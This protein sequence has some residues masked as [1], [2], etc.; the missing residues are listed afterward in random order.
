MTRSVYSCSERPGPDLFVHFVGEEVDQHVLRDI[1]DSPRS[2]K[3]DIYVNLVLSRRK[4]LSKKAVMNGKLDV[5]YAN[6]KE[7]R[8]V[9]TEWT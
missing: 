6:H 9:I 2:P 4:N 8:S 7:L 1:S 3:E 5:D